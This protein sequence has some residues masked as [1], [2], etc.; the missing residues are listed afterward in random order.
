M[1]KV[2]GV[3]CS[4]RRQSNTEVLVSR[5]LAGA[6]K[7]GA[8]TSLFAF[9]RM[10][11]APCRACLACNST[12]RCVVKDDMQPVYDAIDGAGAL[13]LG[14]PIYLDHV[15]AQAKIFID[16]LFPY[17]GPDLEHNFPKGAKLVLVFTQ[18]HPE[19]DAYA[20][21]IASIQHILATYFDLEASEVIVAEGC[22]GPG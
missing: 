16:R 4:P 8:G 11:V 22:N 10:T 20:D 3:S 17:L 18:G 6:E 19:A 12:N 5:A 9:S 21:V 14:T 1:G 13:V 15:A 7:A 2:V